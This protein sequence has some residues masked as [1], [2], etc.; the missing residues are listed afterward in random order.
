[1][2]VKEE[3]VVTRKP[4]QKKE[5]EQLELEVGRTTVVQADGTKVTN[6]GRLVIITH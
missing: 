3:K 4:R 1:M 5:E 6:T 2:E